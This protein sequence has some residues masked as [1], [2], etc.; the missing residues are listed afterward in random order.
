M[1]VFYIGCAVFFAT[2][3][4]FSMLSL[5][6]KYA[7]ATA[8]AQRL[9]LEAA[10]QAM[11]AIGTSH[12]PGTFLAFALNEVAGLIVS[13]VMLRSNIFGKAAAYVGILGFVLLIVF[14]ICSAFVPAA[15]DAAILFAMGGGILSMIWYVL[16]AL[17]LFQ[18]ARLDST[19]V[20]Q[21]A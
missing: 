15:Y 6:N 1:I 3:T 9:P 21:P 5:S 11:L 19:S 17:R 20:P 13:L 14:E 4:A 10:G 7:S 8:D 12:S 18:L 16:I 2:N